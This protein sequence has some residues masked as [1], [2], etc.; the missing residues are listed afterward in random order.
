MGAA[1]AAGCRNENAAL[2]P[3]PGSL[4]LG[5]QRHFFSPVGSTISV[6]PQSQTA[7]IPTRT[8]ELANRGL[9]GRRVLRGKRFGES[10]EADDIVPEL[11]SLGA[12][13]DRR[14]SLAPEPPAHSATRSPLPRAAARSVGRAPSA[15]A[16]RF[17]LVFVDRTRRWRRRWCRRCQLPGCLPVAVRSRPR[18]PRERASP[19]AWCRGAR[20][21]LRRPLPRRRTITTARS[22]T[23]SRTTSP[24]SFARRRPRGRRPRTR[25]PTRSP[26]MWRPG[27]TTRSRRRARWRCSGARTAT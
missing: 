11:L 15:R 5:R 12:A 9:P 18:S 14:G 3:L 22:F 26:R 24:S 2:S 16:S 10:S 13:V 8:S 1:R 20:P 4:N 6:E 17:P 27:T 19:R 23:P 7:T 25:L 21:R